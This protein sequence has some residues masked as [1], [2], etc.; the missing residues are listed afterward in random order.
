VIFRLN[1]AQ[2]ERI[3]KRRIR[4]IPEADQDATLKRSIPAT[5]FRSRNL[6][7]VR[8]TIDEKGTPKEELFFGVN[9]DRKTATSSSLAKKDARMTKKPTDEEATRNLAIYT[10]H[11]CSIEEK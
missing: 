4:S 10:G 11:R 5:D 7:T 9:A 2:A 6:K 3:S 8:R 1:R